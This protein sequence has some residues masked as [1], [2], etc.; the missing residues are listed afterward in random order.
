MADSVPKSISESDK[1]PLAVLGHQDEGV[2]FYANDSE[3]GHCLCTVL[4]AGAF[5][6]ARSFPGFQNIP[7]C[8]VGICPCF[9][10]LCSAVVG[11]GLR[12]TSFI[13]QT[14]ADFPHHPRT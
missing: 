14:I 13:G 4:L 10:L 2:M 3:C 11:Y 7:G 8:G 1:V 12:F 5:S 6:L 9:G